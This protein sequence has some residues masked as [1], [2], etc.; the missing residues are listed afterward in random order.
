[1]QSIKS[2]H[3]EAGFTLLELLLVVGVGALLLIGGIATY[4]LVSEGN[5]VTDTTRMIMT[6]R[7]EAQNLSQGQEYTGVDTALVDAKVMTANPQR[8]P[9]GGQFSVTGGADTLDIEVT[10]LPVN[11][12]RKLAL[13][14]KDPGVKLGG[15][16]PPDTLADAPC[17]P[18]D[19]NTLKWTFP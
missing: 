3:S 18:G 16:E 8:N 6:I 13:S 7:N 10:K 12:C 4:R 1:M 11:A 14:I 5:K 2:K 9:F 17:S 15:A 19:E